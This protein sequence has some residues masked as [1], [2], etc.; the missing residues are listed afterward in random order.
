MLSTE[1][2]GGSTA[3]RRNG[4]ASHGEPAQTATTRV[5]AARTGASV[6]MPIKL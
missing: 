2:I 1:S 6:G 5:A 3:C 4:S